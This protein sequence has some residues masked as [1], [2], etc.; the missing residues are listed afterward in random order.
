M[1]WRSCIYEGWVRHRRFAVAPNVFRYRLF[2]MFIDLAEMA[3]L[4]ENRW[5][6]SDRRLALARFRREDHFGDP[7]MP[8]DQAVRDLVQARVGR[9][10]L[11]R[12]AVLTHLR[13]FGF[14][15]NPVS[16]YYCYE[17]NSD[18]IEAIVLEVQNTPWRERHLY[19]LAG[20][21]QKRT[22]QFRI[23]K[24]FHVSPFLGMDIDYDMVITPPANRLL[25]HMKCSR[26]GDPHLDA[27]LQLRRTEITGTSL[28]RVLCQYPLMT[29]KVVAGIYWQALKLW[30]KKCP[31]FNHPGPELHKGVS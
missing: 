23:A 15:M 16:I 24:E 11:G 4:F 19:V 29:L 22:N 27:T 5:F 18:R 10:P 30:W 25:V 7:A 26:A 17:Q 31:I 9:R 1:S 21:Q 8:L 12:I 28:A 6:W 2:M 14:V 20:D 3:T 13:Y